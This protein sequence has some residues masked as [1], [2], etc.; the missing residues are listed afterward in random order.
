MS[1][2]RFHSLDGLRGVCALVVV[3]FHCSLILHSGLLLN[4]GWL[5]VDVFFVLSGFVIALRYEAELHERGGFTRFL[6]ARAKRL[7][8]VQVLGTICVALAMLAIAANGRS[9]TVLPG[10][11]GLA[12]AFGILLIP[13]ISFSQRPMV[14]S[15]EA[16]PA[17]PPLWSLFDEWIA[18]LLYSAAL[19]R[20]KTR[21]AVALCTICWLCLLLHAWNF[22]LGW[23][24]GNHVGQLIIGA[25]RAIS[26]FM[27][28]VVVSRLLAAGDLDR[29]PSLRPELI[30]LFWILVASVP[31]ARALPL[32]ECLAATLGAAFSV[33]LLA[34]SDRPV[35][36]FFIWLGAISYPLYA[37]HIA[38][39]MLAKAGLKHG[40]PHDAFLAVPMVAASVALA[41]AVDRAIKFF[42]H[43]GSMPQYSRLISRRLLGH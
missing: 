2:K 33:A 7:V 9:Q 10:F 11:T 28:G 27:A 35:P 29:L 36:G 19:H 8:P 32:F 38:V 43:A 5:S 6:F 1:A 24:A 18:N 40:E 37:S 4:H 41:L 20:L 21:H 31:M 25:I 39:V 15:P 26:E 22:Q 12:A 16:F 34:R 23:D 14:T 30:Y 13:N 42:V 17:N 3:F